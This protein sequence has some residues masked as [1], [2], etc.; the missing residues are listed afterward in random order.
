MAA[1]ALQLSSVNVSQSPIH[2]A[3]RPQIAAAD[4]DDRRGD[5][6]HGAGGGGGQD[7]G[8]GDRRG[9]S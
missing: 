7:D 4:R 8:R 1:G 3:P 5:T 2:A 9:E 6:A